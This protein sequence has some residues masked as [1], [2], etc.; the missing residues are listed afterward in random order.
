MET[1]QVRCAPR[2]GNVPGLPDP[3]YAA[4]GQQ[5]FDVSVRQAIP[6]APPDRHKDHLRRKPEPGKPDLGGGT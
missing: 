5:L 2:H 1:V 4:F 6:Q 3:S